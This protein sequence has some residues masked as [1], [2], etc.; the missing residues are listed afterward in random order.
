[1]EVYPIFIGFIKAQGDRI[2]SLTFNLIAVLPEH[3]NYKMR[4][5]LRM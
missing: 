4:I 2:N 5:K 3:E 1:M